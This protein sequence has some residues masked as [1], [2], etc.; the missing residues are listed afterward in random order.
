MFAWHPPTQQQR[1]VVLKQLLKDKRHF[2]I[3]T[4]HYQ[5]QIPE[6]HMQGIVYRTVAWTPDGRP[7][8]ADTRTTQHAADIATSLGPTKVV[9]EAIS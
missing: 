2:K 6:L 3:K 1:S 8:P 9:P 7:H 4:T 5:R